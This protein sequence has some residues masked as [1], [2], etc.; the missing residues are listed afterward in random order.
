MTHILTRTLLTTAMLMAGNLLLP[1]AP[2]YSESAEEARLRDLADND[3]GHQKVR[4]LLTQ[5]T[6]PNVR[7]FKGR[8]AVH[9]AAG[10]CAKKNLEVILKHGGDATV[11]D[12]DGNTPLH[13]AAGA[14]GVELECA[15]VT[16]LLVQHD[17]PVNQAN[18]NGNTAL[19]LAAKGSKEDIMAVLL[20]AGANP[21]AINED[22][23]T[24]LQ[25]FVKDG[26]NEGRIVA[27]LLDAGAN[28]NRKTPAGYTPLHVTLKSVG[29]GK[30][31]VVEALLAGDADPCI[32][33]PEGH[34]PY[35]YGKVHENENA[36]VRDA[37][38]RAGGHDLACDRRTDE[39]KQPEEARRAEEAKQTE[40]DRRAEPLRVGS[41][42]RDCNDC[43]E[44]VVV[45]AGTPFAVGKYEVTFAEWEACV[46]GGGCGGYSPD[47]EGWGRGRRP[48]INVSWEDVQAYVR[49]LSEQTGEAYRLLSEAEWEYAVRAGTTTHYTWGDEIGR[50]RANCDGCGSGWDNKQTAPVGSFAANA[51][52]LHDVH[53]NVWEWTQDCWEGDCSV[54]VLRG[55][56]W[57][58]KPRDLRVAYRYTH[59]VWIRYDY[60]GVRVART[61]TP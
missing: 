4:E 49:W 30:T 17:A 16:R 32:R 15:P 37:L 27:L 31:E 12:T 51:F 41:N 19:H 33:D 40:K 22:G 13:H 25:L 18:Q 56:S 58:L 29:R 24:P 3:Q 23:L 26:T 21:R 36:M 46:A 28:P 48:V 47:D 1:A 14:I 34:I 44:M 10:G 6:N 57:D 8:T 35:Q 54:R 60:N 43:P 59:A 45:P 20:D 55:G 39:A 11:R 50:N 7:D 52:G 61:L 53:G 42:F 2:A 38:D 9:A 5:G